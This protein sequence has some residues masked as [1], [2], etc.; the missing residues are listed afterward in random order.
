MQKGNTI[1]KENPKRFVRPSKKK[2][3]A[4]GEVEKRKSIAN[5]KKLIANQK[6]PS[7][8]TPSN[9][10]NVNGL[11]RTMSCGFGATVKNNFPTAKSGFGFGKFKNQK[12]SR[13]GK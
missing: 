4:K 8:Q 7:C 3:S 9:R 13:I 5:D 2:M 12:V 11:N 10:N 6:K 1:K